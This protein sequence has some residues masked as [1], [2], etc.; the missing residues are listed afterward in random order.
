MISQPMRNS[1]ATN[2]TV[3]WKKNYPD[4]SMRDVDTYKAFMADFAYGIRG[5]GGDP[6]PSA[7][8]II[9]YWAVLRGVLRLR[10]TPVSHDLHK[11]VNQVSAVK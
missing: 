11:P 2:Y 6:T 10:G 7:R 8:T 5:M 1:L 4:L 3:S 9:G